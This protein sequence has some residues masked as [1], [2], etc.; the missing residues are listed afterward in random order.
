MAARAKTRNGI[1]TAWRKKWL[2]KSGSTSATAMI[3]ARPILSWRIGNT[4]MSAA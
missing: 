3:T 2:A 4:A 1:I